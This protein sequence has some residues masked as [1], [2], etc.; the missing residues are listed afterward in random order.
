MTLGGVGCFRLEDDGTRNVWIVN[1]DPAGLLIVFVNVKSAGGYR[2]I[3][4]LLFKCNI[5]CL[6]VLALRWSISNTLVLGSLVHGHRYACLCVD[7]VFLRSLVKSLLLDRKQLHVK[8]YNFSVNA[9]PNYYR[10]HR[11]R[12]TLLVYRPMSF[13]WLMYV[14]RFVKEIG[15]YLRLN[16]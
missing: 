12:N 16:V 13:V 1:C 3:N 4:I 5:P 2:G 14:V 8:I 15:M 6:T 7:P 9:T 11:I 10:G